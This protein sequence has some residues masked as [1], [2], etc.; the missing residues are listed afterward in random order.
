MLELD[1]PGCYRELEE[2]YPELRRRVIF[3]TGDAL[4][5]DARELLGR[6]EVSRL[7]QAIGTRHL[8]S[9]QRALQARHEVYPRRL[10]PTARP[11]AGK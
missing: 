1:G 11:A 10:T 4:S 2:R 3:L 6:V 9:K 8:P 5:P 7:S